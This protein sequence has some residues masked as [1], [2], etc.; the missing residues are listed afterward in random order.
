MA[1]LGNGRYE[2]YTTSGDTIQFNDRDMMEIIQ[3]MQR[4]VLG[5]TPK[6]GE[7]LEDASISFVYENSARYELLRT[8][9]KDDGWKNLKWSDELE[10]AMD[11]SME[12]M[13]QEASDYYEKNYYF[14][15]KY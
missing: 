12:C 14:I 10:D 2:I 15:P 6:I 1:Y 5:N 7:H 3:E 9:I 13:A 11:I 4:E 8:E